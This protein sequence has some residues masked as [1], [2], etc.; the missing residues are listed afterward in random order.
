MVSREDRGRAAR[1]L[2]RRTIHGPQTVEAYLRATS[3]PRYMQRLREMEVEFDAQRRRL[4]A[5]YAA[6]LAAHGERIETFAVRWR[7]TARAW[8]F[9]RL[10]ELI[11]QHNTWYP[12]EADLPMSPQTRDYVAVGG[13]SYRRIELGPDWILEHFPPNQRMPQPPP[14]PLELPREPAARPR[15]AGVQRTFA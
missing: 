13:R 3:P 1:R 7:T 6:L 5:A 2:G 9:D 14:A 12:V 10:N 11:R 4:E 8:R 15:A